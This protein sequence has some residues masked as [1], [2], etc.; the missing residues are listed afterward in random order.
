MFDLPLEERA[1][2]KILSRGA[3]LYGDRPFVEF[4]GE[5]VSYSAAS[6]RANRVANALLPL[7]V[8]KGTR[9]GLLLS[10]RLEYLDLWFG[11]A[12][13]GA[14]QLPINTAYRGPQIRHALSRAALPVVVVERALAGELL[15][16]LP[17]VSGCRHL[18]IIDDP[19][20]TKGDA[21]V[22]VHRYEDLLAAASDAAPPSVDVGGADISAI[23][24]TSGTTGP[25]KGVLLPHGQQ[26]W[27]A[28]SM[29][30]AM[31][32]TEADTYYNF[33]P[34][35]HNTAQAM[36]TLPVMLTGGRM[37]LRDRFSLSAF[38]DDIRTHG[39]TAFYFI[40]E[41]LRLILAGTSQQDARGHRLRIG[42]AS[43]GYR[44]T[45]RRSTPGSASGW[46]PATA[47]PRA[48]FR[49]SARWA[50]RAHPSAVRCRNSTSASRMRSTGNCRP[51]RSASSSRGARNRSP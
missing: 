19:P 29:A 25:S 37:L 42:W 1:A 51:G 48:T 28:R 38:W 17:S 5:V 33:F 40:G 31:A 7:G 43:V 13:I 35:F 14:I 26:Y 11:L 50:R 10:N 45:T 34:L 36:I 39:I 30:M 21:T 24:N 9:V 46:A 49:C 4:Q 2:G 47:R 16:V 18:V 20:G 41:I 6:R 44:A 23:M 12:R 15:A 32:L 27:L 3:E 22:P 8:G